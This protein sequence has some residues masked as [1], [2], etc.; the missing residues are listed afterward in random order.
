ML[1]VLRRDFTHMRHKS[2]DR[3]MKVVHDVRYDVEFE[4]APQMVKVE[5]FTANLL[6]TMKTLDLTSK[7]MTCWGLDSAEHCSTLKF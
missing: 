7:P 2:R 4:A 6:A 3:F 5:S 1:S